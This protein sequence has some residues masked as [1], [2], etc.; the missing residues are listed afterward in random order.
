MAFDGYKLTSR[1]AILEEKIAK[2]LGQVNQFALTWHV[3]LSLVGITEAY[4]EFVAELW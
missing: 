3:D 2:V 1:V 4:D